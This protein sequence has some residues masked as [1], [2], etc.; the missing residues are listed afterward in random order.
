MDSSLFPLI[1]FQ[2]LFIL[3]LKV[4]LAR[5]LLGILQQTRESWQTVFFIAAGV[6]A[7]GAIM[8]CI[9]GSGVV[10]PW[11][12]K[13]LPTVEMEVTA[14][15]NGSPSSR[16]IYKPHLSNGSLPTDPMLTEKVQRGG[17]IYELA[18]R[19]S[20][21]L[22][23]SAPFCCQFHDVLCFFSCFK[24]VGFIKERNVPP[25]ITTCVIIIIINYY[26]Q[27][28]VLICDQCCMC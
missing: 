22:H 28:P 23:Y 14:V 12:I 20:V 3:Y 7:F 10:Q 16:P 15:E 4:N 2:D 21:S 17:P 24:Y 13:Q 9:L 18:V 8:Y 25:A 11:A 5:Q 6:Y 1:N 19:N 26:Q 27:Y